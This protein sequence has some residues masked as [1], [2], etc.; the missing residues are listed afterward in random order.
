MRVKGTVI[1]NYSSGKVKGPVP[2]GGVKTLLGML[3]CVGF[4]ASSCFTVRARMNGKFQTTKGSEGQLTIDRSF[5][6]ERDGAACGASIMLFG[7][8]C[9]AYLYMPWVDQQDQMFELADE[10][11]SKNIGPGKYRI[12]D[13]AVT[14]IG[15]KKSEPTLK[16]KLNKDN[17]DIKDPD[18][19]DNMVAAEELGQVL[20]PSDPDNR[21][22]HT[23]IWAG[24][25]GLQL[26]LGSSFFL[27]ATRR[28]MGY[29]FRVGTQ[30]GNEALI[31][32]VPLILGG[33]YRKGLFSVHSS[34]SL[35]VDG[36]HRGIVYEKTLSTEDNKTYGIVCQRKLPCM[37]RGVELERNASWT[38]LFYELAG[39]VSTTDRHP[40]QGFFEGGVSWN[41]FTR[42]K[43]RE[44]DGDEAFGRPRGVGSLYNESRN[45]IGFNGQ[46][47]GLN[48]QS[49]ML[50]AGVSIDFR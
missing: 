48:A 19:F 8:W 27:G 28:Q 7:G 11:L 15:Y 21:A 31:L 24:E 50:K 41:V 38:M 9:W 29:S 34:F 25:A 32:G 47:A 37:N 13:R 22:Q 17:G 35:F 49:P 14:R 18:L 2:D 36:G 3:A 10:L 23:P 26:R 46:V 30:I 33:A 20:P 42:L 1:S 6:V 43:V 39:R 4:L 40:I 44:Q 5:P 16:L 45:G 12:Q